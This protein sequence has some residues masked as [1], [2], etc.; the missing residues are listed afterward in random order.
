[1]ARAIIAVIVAYI[2]MFIL[3]FVTFTCMYLLLGA[4]MAFKPASYEASNLCGWRWLSR[5]ISSSPLSA[6]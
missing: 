4:D 6:V 3:V 1:M 5:L 2:V